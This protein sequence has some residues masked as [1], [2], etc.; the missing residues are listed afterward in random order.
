MSKSMHGAQPR[1]SPR[2]SSKNWARELAPIE[3]RP[4][5][6]VWDV[7]NKCNLRCVMCHFSYDDVFHRKAKYTTPAEFEVI[8]ARTLPRAHMLILSAG[9]E[10][11]TSPYFKEILEIAAKYEV[12][13]LLYITNGTR[14]T[15]K[16]VDASIH[17]GVTQVQVSIDGSTKET[18][19]HIRRGA[20]FDRLVK[21][22][23]YLQKRKAELGSA[24]PR[25]QFNIVLMRQNLEEL[26]RFIDLAEEVGAEWIAARHLL[27]MNGLNMED[28]SLYAVPETANRYFQKFLDRSAASDRVKVIS[29]PDLFDLDALRQQRIAN[30]R[31]SHDRPFGAVDVPHGDRL[32]IGQ[33]VLFSGWA[34]DLERVVGV[35]LEREATRDDRE[36]DLNEWGRVVINEAKIGLP[37][38]DVAEI[39][40]D[41]PRSAEAG[42][43]VKLDGFELPEAGHPVI[44][45]V[46]AYAL[47]HPPADL[48]TFTILPSA[49]DG[50]ADALRPTGR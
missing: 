11:L 13:D 33:G 28:Q 46:V 41:F 31:V 44:V 21:N 34:L 17:N 50:A 22:L 27:V 14:L 23:K 8:A 26:E 1:T 30:R 49:L 6:V 45:Y 19:E 2:R 12:P 39:Y 38:S 10:P 9:N 15:P 32:A 24:T 5:K 7:S 47:G 35:Q 18:Y 25:L 20:S 43:R 3:G 4:L 48:G 36:D 40:P 29:F 16:I 37:R 42:W